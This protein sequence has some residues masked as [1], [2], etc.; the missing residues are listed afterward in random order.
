M[1]SAQGVESSAGEDGTPP[2][3]P[4]APPRDKGTAESEYDAKVSASIDVL[5]KCAAPDARPTSR[6][7]TEA[8]SFLAN[9]GVRPEAWAPVLCARPWRLV[10][11]A[12]PGELK[13]AAADARGCARPSD[14]TDA[15]PGRFLAWDGLQTFTADRELESSRRFLRGAGAVTFCGSYEL[16]NRRMLINFHTLR[17]ALIFGFLNLRFDLREGRG[18]RA[19]VERWLRP[20]GAEG[21]RKPFR[22][23]PNVYVWCYADAHICIAQVASGSIGVWAA[24]GGS[25]PEKRST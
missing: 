24:A 21:A 2:S 25:D 8:L 5:R 22:K 18:L 9:A 20:R 6:A 19:F 7:A 4:L 13:A 10:F 23:K 11:V 3:R 1:F 17:V 15:P 16:R 14:L 12:R